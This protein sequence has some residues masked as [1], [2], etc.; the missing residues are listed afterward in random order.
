MS[1]APEIS[2]II[3]VYNDAS[4]IS[5]SLDALKNFLNSENINA[6]II[7]INDG[8]KDATAKIVEDRIQKYPGVRFINRN[9]N[10]GKG[11]S[12]REGLATSLGGIM[13]F[14]DAD[15]PYGIKCFKRII[16]MIN[17]GADLVIANR[18]LAE[19]S[20]KQKNLG[21][22]RELTHWGFAFLVRNLLNLNFS[23]TQAGLK[24][25]KKNAAIVLLPKLTIDRYAF[26]LELLLA[27]KKAGLKIREVPVA[28][29]NIG[30]SNI[31]VLRDSWQ[32]F[33]DIVRIWARN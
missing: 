2:I 29:E 22:L 32:M 18:N 15:L 6:E 19:P 3:P 14:T 24:A 25:I 26:D 11:Y 30:K 13:I 28:L 12:I 5:K 7:I 31:S 10:K 8:G 33:K 20:I 27:A 1:L 17:D 21:I 4:S 23:D 9:V 16:E